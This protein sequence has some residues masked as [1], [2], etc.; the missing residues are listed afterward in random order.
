MVFIHVNKKNYNKYQNTTQN[1]ITKLDEF[2]LNKK[3]FIIIYMEGCGPC[4]AARPEWKKLENILKNYTNNN[5]VAIVDI[6]KDL[7]HKVK[8]IKNQPSGFPTIIYI[9]NKGETIENFE[10]SDII[11]KNRSIDSFVEWIKSKEN[12]ENKTK[13]TDKSSSKNQ[14]R[15]GKTKKRLYTKWSSKYKR[16]IKC[17]RPKGFSQK[18]YCKYGRK[19]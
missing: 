7:I 18:Q 6:D 10:D 19:K 8:Y 9:T 14:Q 3:V 1:P 15:G 2:L 17:R 4:I 5:E 13:H 16:S 11:N 12:V